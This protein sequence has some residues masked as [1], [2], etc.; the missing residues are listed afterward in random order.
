MMDNQGESREASSMAQHILLL[1]GTTEARALAVQLAPR[2]GLTVTLSLAGRTLNPAALPVPV[3]IG[4]FGGA[5]GLEAFLREY[6]IAA[7]LDATHP[8][9]ARISANAHL[10]ARRAGVP[11]LALTRPAWVSEPGDDWRP[12]AD[13]AA[14]CAALG[15]VPRRVFL[16]LGRQEVAAFAAAPQHSYLI[17]SVDP[18]IPAPVMPQVTCLTARGPFTLVD[19]EALLDAHGIEGIV[20]K[21]S[22][23]T[24]TFAKLV[25]ARARRLPVFMLARPALPDAPHAATVGEALAW[26]DHA[27]SRREV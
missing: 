21:N 17:R 8:Y 1:G 11:L 6:R 3:R 13:V 7:L 2:A 24:A 14:A 23:G 9:A 10:A 15:A 25:A 12:V 4:G 5:A 22:G 19:E 26:L 16:A 27:L 20:C 18:I